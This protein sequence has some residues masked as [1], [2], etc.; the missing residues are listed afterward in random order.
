MNTVSMPAEGYVFNKSLN[1]LDKAPADGV[2]AVFESYQDDSIKHTLQQWM[3]LAM[4]SEQENDYD[5]GPARARLMLF[6]HDLQRVIEALYLLHLRN[7]GNG[8]LAA[9]IRGV[10]R[11]SE[12]EHANPVGVLLAFR[13]RYNWQHSHTEIWHLLDAAVSYNGPTAPDRHNLIW[14]FEALLCLL[15]AAYHYY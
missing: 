5:E 9:P 2:Y 15:E 7:Q 3:V 6:C 12:G 4:G 14:D 8:R 11:L 1:F 10:S 13:S